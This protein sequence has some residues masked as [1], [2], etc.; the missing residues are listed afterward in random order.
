ML[1]Y[2]V[3]KL[4]SLLLPVFLFSVQ[5]K[6]TYIQSNYEA[7]TLK[8][9]EII[10]FSYNVGQQLRIKSESYGLTLATFVFTETSARH[11]MKGDD[12]T[13]FG[14]TQFQVIRAREVLEHSDYF[15]GLLTLSD[16]ELA[17]LLLTNDYL[18]IYLCGLNFKLNLQR[19]KNYS[20]AIRAH[21]GYN[22]SMNFYNRRYYETFINNMQ[23]IKKVIH[24]THSI[25][26]N[27][28]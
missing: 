5:L 8:Q 26:L 21:N 16:T 12:D 28:N 7:L 19:Y 15:S 4:L 1:R 25:R 20:A 13:S 23:I 11:S 22:P 9:K 17:H 3:L 2:V 18:N 27:Q 24:D 10:I 14:L 6:P